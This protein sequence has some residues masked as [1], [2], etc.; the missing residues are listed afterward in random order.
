MATHCK[1]VGTEGIHKVTDSRR[2]NEVIEED[3]PRKRKESAPVTVSLVILIVCPF[4]DSGFAL[5]L[6]PHLLHRLH[7][8][9][10]GILQVLSTDILELSIFDL[11]V[12][13]RDPQAY[14]EERHSLS[15]PLALFL[16]SNCLD[17]QWC[18][19]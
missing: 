6:R 19:V 11:G 17:R 14:L 18:Y 5:Q 13:L 2:N 9:G 16:A 4:L 10:C 15:Y 3:H 8:R 12:E 1:L 7:S